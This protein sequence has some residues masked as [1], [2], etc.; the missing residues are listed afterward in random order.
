MAAVK[1]EA[2]GTLSFKIFGLY[3]CPIYA[4]VVFPSGALYLLFL[5]QT[6]LIALFKASFTL[7]VDRLHFKCPRLIFFYYAYAV[8]I[9]LHFGVVFF[10]FPS[11]LN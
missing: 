10:F 1:K 5:A 9:L 4:F 7:E 2:F 3:D 8:T 11:K 6:L